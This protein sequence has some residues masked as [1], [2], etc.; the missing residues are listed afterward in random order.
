[1]L[2]GVGLLGVACAYLWA[3]KPSATGVL[4][5]GS[6]AI[7]AAPEQA[8]A[9][10]GSAR[11]TPQERL[12][13][14]P[15][16]VLQRPL[17]G[18]VQTRRGRALEGARV[19]AVEPSAVGGSP[20][21]TQSDG[22]GAFQLELESAVSPT[23]LAS[24]P[25]YKSSSEGPIDP[26]QYNKQP[27]AV[28]L[29]LD[30]GGVTV[31]GSVLDAAGGPIAGAELRASNSEDHVVAFELSNDSG[32][33][34]LQVAP[35]PVRILARAD[36]YSEELRG[37]EAPRAGLEI[38]LVA[39]ASIVG[40]V[41][42][43]GTGEGVEGVLVN[44]H[45]DDDVFSVTRSARSERDGAFRLNGMR[46]GSYLLQG[47]ATHWRSEEQRVSLTPA[48]PPA[49][50]DIVVHTAARL[51]GTVQLGGAPCTQGLVS[52]AG[53]LS[54]SAPTGPEG[55]IA[56]EGVIAGRY[57]VSVDCEGAR[58]RD[59]LD[60][61]TG[62]V[63]RVWSLDAGARVTG[64]VL[65]ANGVPVA[66]LQVDV[67][68][69]GPSA[70]RS[71]TTCMTDE[72][73]RFSCGGLT[74]GDYTVQ[75]LGV[76]S[77]VDPVTVHATLESSPEVT[78]RLHEQGAIRIRIVSPASFDP[79]TFSLMASRPNQPALMAQ[80]SGDAFVF[81]PIPLGDYDVF[82]DSD[83]SR[84]RKRVTLSRDGE[85]VELTLEMP[86]LHSL[87]GRVVDQGGAA[88][89]EAWVRASRER[90]YG[91]A[92]PTEPVLTDND[93]RFVLKGLVPG[94]YSL[95]ASDGEQRGHLDRVASDGT[96]VVVSAQSVGSPSGTL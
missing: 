34:E 72:L 64:T 69:S 39:A 22:A 16:E 25:G 11:R 27:R 51:S 6:A 43:E 33:F 83:P 9:R 1:M 56:L 73:G 8:R 70:E 3:R 41:I 21:C 26:R 28:V 96:N 88:L 17:T 53:P 2:G 15:R 76:L 4:T 40:R 24:H 82:I 49:S 30:T 54:L 80:L 29:T 7:G 79:S 52:V 65:S 93:G 13:E 71:G 46:S 45:C 58:S 84:S 74:P 60:I 89:P 85:V 61:G 57:E 50:V 86:Q 31:T 38:R 91:F 77:Q 5:Q 19:C 94:R 75:T 78:L 14:A 55:R 32:A 67:A 35:G 90:E 68:P 59:T 37:A 48:Q 10:G 66:A 62:D 18:R 47:I 63:D 12:G 23:V 92:S 87:E 81:D 36:G 95:D 20:V 44:A 42:A